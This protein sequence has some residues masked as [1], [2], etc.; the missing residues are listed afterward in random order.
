MEDWD[1][2]FEKTAYVTLCRNCEDM[3]DVASVD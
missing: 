2:A 1:R 3:F